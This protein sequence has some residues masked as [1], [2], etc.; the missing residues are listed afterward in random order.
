ML[1][2]WKMVLSYKIKSWLPPLK[3]NFF[4]LN[5]ELKSSFQMWHTFLFTSAYQ[6]SMKI[7]NS[8]HD[9]TNGLLQAVHKATRKVNFGGF[10]W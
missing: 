6:G 10:N 8:S 7:L 1:E 2:N 9:F 3:F 5:C 4:K